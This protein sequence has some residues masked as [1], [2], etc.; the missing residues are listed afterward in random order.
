MITIAAVL[1]AAVVANAQ[2]TSAPAATGSAVVAPSLASTNPTAIPLTSIY[3]S[4]PTQATVALRTTYTAG[5]TPPISGAP[6][7]PSAVITPANWPALDQIPP[8][9]SP[10]VKQ[11]I[12]EVANSGVKIP[13]V[14]QTQLGGCAEPANA[15]ALANATA[16]GNCWWTCGGCSRETDITTCPDKATWGLSFDD[17]PSPYTPDLL[18]YLDDN[19]IKSTFFVVG[20]RAISRPQILQAEYMGGHQLSVHTWSHPTLTTLTNEQ[21]I[22]ELGWTR[23]AIKQITGVTPNTMRPP[24]G[25]ID[26]RV[27]AIANAMKLTPII[28]TSANGGSFDTNDWHI[29]SGLTS[30]Q[31]LNSFD[32]ILD[33]AG[34]LS[35]GFIVLAH[36]LYQQT[37]D[38]A[39]GY[40]LPDAQARKFNMMSIV[41]CLKKPL[42]DAYIETSSNSSSPASTGTHTA[43]GSQSTGSSGSNNGQS[44]GTSGASRAVGSLVGALVGIA[45]G[46]AL[47]L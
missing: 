37:V 44:S 40:V 16:Q 7:L 29:P 39:V 42:A 6:P 24:Y 10:Q 4:A 13:S 5:A 45:A 27:R 21:I 46:V 9:D 1:A 41:E 28:W 11:W 32:K 34:E 30:A 38:L 17:G 33:T 23:E 12:Q 43:S 47:L 26:D 25:D 15:A 35:S 2:T 31:V 3:A 18:N 14:A 8:L 19:K 22:A 36:D 20:S